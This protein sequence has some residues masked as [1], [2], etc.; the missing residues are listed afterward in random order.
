MRNEAWIRCSGHVLN[1]VAQAVLCGEEEHAFEREVDNIALEEMQLRIWRRRGPLG[2]VHNL[3]YWIVRLPQHN[4]RLM[5]MQR[6]L[7]APG[8]PDDKKE[9]YEVIKDVTT[10]WTFFDDAAARAIYLR[11]AIDE[12]LL[13]EEVKHQQHE[14][15]FRHSSNATPMKPR[16]AAPILQDRLDA[17]DWNVIALYH[18]I[19]APIRR[20]TMNL[21]GHVDGCY[22]AIWLVIEGSR[23]CL[24]T[25][26][27][28]ASNTQSTKH[29]S[30]TRHG[31]G[32]RG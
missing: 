14:T 26:S 21:E 32:A 6:Q 20:A 16:A 29:C 12:L 1:L 22:G 24:L 17:D 15:R 11:P 9:T 28:C 8:R 7:I 3:V 25:S 30:V 27:S 23:N 18:E 2:K 5:A 19:L 31:S 13:Q 10:R 4:D